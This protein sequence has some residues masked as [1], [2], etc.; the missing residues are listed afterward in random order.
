MTRAE[1]ATSVASGAPD[2]LGPVEV[3]HPERLAIEQPQ[4]DGRQPAVDAAAHLGGH[5]GT[6]EAL[7]Q[8]VG[9]AP[10][11][12]RRHLRAAPAHRELAGVRAD[13]G[14]AGHRVREGE[15]AVVDQQDR[16]LRRHLAGHRPP[17]RV[18]LLPLVRRTIPVQQPDPPHQPQEVAH[19][20]VHHHGV[21]L[22]LTDRGGQ[23]RA[24][25]GGRARHLEVEA[26]DRR[27]RRRVRA[28]PVRHDDAVELP[29]VPQ[30]PPDEVGLL[31]AVDAV[32]LVVGRHHG[33]HARLPHG[34]LERREVDLAQGSL[35]DLGADRHP[36]VLLVVAGVVLDAAPDTT[37]LHALHVG[38]GEAGR[39][40]RVLGE[41][42]EGAAGQGS[43]HD[44]HRRS[45]Q[46][47]DS[48][49][50]RLG[51]QD[52]A[53]A[54]HQR[55]VPG[56]PDRRAA[57]Q[58]QGAATDEA[59]AP[60]ARRP[61]GD[62]ERRE[63][64]SLDGREVPQAGA[65]RE[66]ALLVE[67]HR[68]HEAIDLQVEGDLVAHHVSTKGRHRPGTVDQWARGPAAASACTKRARVSAGSITSSISKCTATFSAFPCS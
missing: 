68:L 25:P 67:G 31:A 36:L 35:G 1:W 43:A 23:R 45:E 2:R 18:L 62:L 65:G 52:L 40:Q 33:P 56:R 13:D 58:G 54:R 47:V 61:V 32:D 22:P 48:L 39:Q 3:L 46:H 60:H 57:R 26:G 6:G 38:D 34:C 44:A 50:P 63:T 17:A 4:V 16:A 53:Q 41:R 42:L 55:R 51:G 20:A 24:E 7:G 29:L 30:D 27:L 59:V 64:H 28:E 14:H 19:L 49:G 21:D 11:P 10:A 37:P 15:H 9:H 8:R 66:G 5:D 12:E